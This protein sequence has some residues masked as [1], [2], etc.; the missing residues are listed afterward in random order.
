M[1]PK[2]VSLS[3]SFKKTFHSEITRSYETFFALSVIRKTAKFY[4]ILNATGRKRKEESCSCV[5]NLTANLHAFSVFQGVP[6][7]IHGI[8]YLKLLKLTEQAYA[9]IDLQA[10]V[11]TQTKGY[12]KT[13]SCHAGHPKTR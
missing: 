5:T 6:T 9:A 12:L 8:T 13:L 3:F 2:F 1:M 7:Y 10:R 11:D 4:I